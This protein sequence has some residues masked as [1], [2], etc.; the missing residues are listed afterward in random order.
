VLR[1]DPLA[2]ADKLIPLL[3]AYVAYR[4]GD[5]PDADD[6]T[7]DTVERA[8]RYRDR[9]DP[10]KGEPLAWLI[11][12][13]RNCIADLVAAR[14]DVV[15]EPPPEDATDDLEEGTMR[16]LTLRL[17]VARLDERERELIA[18]RY[19]ADLTAR[20]IGAV[21]GMRKNAVE[22]ALHRALARLRAEL[23]REPS[24]EL[25]P[26]TSRAVSS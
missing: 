9:Y 11:G 16:R 14:E 19:G 17:A 6:V 7:G 3:H 5:G 4:L 15:D 20:Q 12:I 2:R 23:D 18:L 8:V 21:L 13:A 25:R 24:L 26:S 22:V 1:R 10:S